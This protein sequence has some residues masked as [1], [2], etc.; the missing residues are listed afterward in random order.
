MGRV[1]YI[2]KL[3]QAVRAHACDTCLIIVWMYSRYNKRAK[4]SGKQRKVNSRETN[5]SDWSKG[6]SQKQKRH[7]SRRDFRRSQ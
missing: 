1:V 6:N 3:G 2:G 7:V 5:V 4:I